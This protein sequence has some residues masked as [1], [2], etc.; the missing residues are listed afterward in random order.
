[1]TIHIQE[2]SESFNILDILTILY[3]AM[4]LALQAHHQVQ[5]L[6]TSYKLTILYL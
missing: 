2:I 4:N 5:G 6:T 1:M 3:T